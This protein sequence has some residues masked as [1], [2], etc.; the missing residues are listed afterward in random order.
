MDVPRLNGGEAVRSL[1]EMDAETVTRI[2]TDPFNFQPPVRSVSQREDVEQLT[3]S[4]NTYLI[5]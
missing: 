5:L 4:L 3:D 1:L 2:K